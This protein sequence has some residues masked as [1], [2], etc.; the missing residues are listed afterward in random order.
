M[1]KDKDAEKNKGEKKKGGIK[2]VPLLLFLLVSPF[3]MPTLLI[4]IGL[5]PALIALI[6]DED[7]DK[8]LA[9]SVGSM[10]L[11]GVVPFIVELWQNG[12]TFENAFYI[13]KQPN[14]W[15]IML[16]A[17]AVGQLIVFVVSPMMASL[18]LNQ[19][20]SRLETLNDSLGKLKEIWGPD[21]ANNQPLEQVRR[22]NNG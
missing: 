13:I 8:S 16:G 20:Q 4:M 15:L 1:A 11:A 10:N 5:L 7:D 19:A 21:V 2:I 22:K 12:Q 3:I 17:A 18:A 14:T 9:I 6:A